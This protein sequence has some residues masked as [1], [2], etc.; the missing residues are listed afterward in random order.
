ML[1]SLPLCAV[2]ALHFTSVAQASPIPQSI[3]APAGPPITDASDL[4]NTLGDLVI[5]QEQSNS[6]ET[7][8]TQ[9][10]SVKERDAPPMDLSRLVA[11]IG[12]FRLPSNVTAGHVVN[13]VK[14]AVPNLADDDAT[15]IV[16]ALRPSTS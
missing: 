5:P 11:D 1:S 10:T 15:N 3:N 2:L 9:T 16:H 7:I 8:P 6:T 14:R 13:A 12:D 4:S